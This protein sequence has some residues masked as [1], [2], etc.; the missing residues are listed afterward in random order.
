MV[1]IYEY[2]TLYCL[3][4]KKKNVIIENKLG[5]DTKISQWHHRRYS[6]NRSIRQIC[7]KIQSEIPY[8]YINI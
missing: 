5:G 4:N 8:I 6:S 3:K 1:Y 2:Q 7:L